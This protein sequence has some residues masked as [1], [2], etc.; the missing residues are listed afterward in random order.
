MDIAREICEEGIGAQKK[1][2][3]VLKYRIFHRKMGLT[4]ALHK[5]S[6][7][8]LGDNELLKEGKSKLKLEEG[9]MQQ[10]RCLE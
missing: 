3:K 1:R 6:A 5:E 9:L 2:R 10:C 7:T 4:R 8:Y